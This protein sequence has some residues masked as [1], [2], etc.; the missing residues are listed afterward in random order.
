MFTRWILFPVAA[1][2]FRSTGK[3]NKIKIFSTWLLLFFFQFMSGVFFFC[4]VGKTPPSRFL[5]FTFYCWLYL[6]GVTVTVMSRKRDALINNSLL[7]S[8]LDGRQTWGCRD[9]GFVLVRKAAGQKRKNDTRVVLSG[10][11][12]KKKVPFAFSFICKTVLLCSCIARTFTVSSVF[13]ARYLA[14][15]SSRSAF[16]VFTL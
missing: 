7:T 12:L 16:V 8:R 9:G 6:I 2:L 15:S 5:R 1:Y 10:R 14:V 13:K 11:V 3:Y 4:F